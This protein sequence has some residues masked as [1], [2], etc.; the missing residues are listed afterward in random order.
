MNSRN[1]MPFKLTPEDENKALSCMT[2]MQSI[3]LGL[4]SSDVRRCVFH[5]LKGDGRQNVQ[6]PSPFI[7]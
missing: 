3:G 6:F 5:T 7:L 4:I 1:E 2:R